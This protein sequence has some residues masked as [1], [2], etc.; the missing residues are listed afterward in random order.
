VP[1]LDQCIAVTA[2]STILA[3]STYTF[4]ASAVPDNHV[5]MITIPFVAF[6]MFRYLFLVYAQELG[7]SPES[8]L[9]RD[10]PLLTAIVLWGMT[11]VAISFL[12]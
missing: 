3:Y 9:F 8:L 4:N 12:R 2:A 10:R 7:S 1:L 5:M 6:A 11:V